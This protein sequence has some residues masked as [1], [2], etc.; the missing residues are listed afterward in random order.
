MLPSDGNEGHNASRA[1]ISRRSRGVN[2]SRGDNCNI[3]MTLN[4]G[5]YRQLAKKLECS[6]GAANLRQS[7]LL[8]VRRK[9]FSRPGISCRCKAEQLL[10]VVG[11]ATVGQ[12]PACLS[13]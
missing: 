6:V 7:W 11:T 9:I 13:R 3:T 12:N 10:V 5:S 1:A 2:F 8:R 4:H